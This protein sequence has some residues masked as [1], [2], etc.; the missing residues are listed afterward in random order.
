LAR[1]RAVVGPSRTSVVEGV[2]SEQL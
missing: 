1:P 2:L